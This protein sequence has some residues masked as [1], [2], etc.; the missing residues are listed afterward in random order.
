MARK[1][2]VIFNDPY[3]DRDRFVPDEDYD[4]NETFGPIEYVSKKRPCLTCETTFQ[5]TWNGNR[6]CPS[7]IKS[8]SRPKYSSEIV[9]D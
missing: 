1:S 6:I 2:P 3:L 8:Q 9:D 5:S 7:C 4:E